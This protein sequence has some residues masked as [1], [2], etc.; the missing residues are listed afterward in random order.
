ME[1]TALSDTRQF[2]QSIQDNSVCTTAVD[3]YNVG[4]WDVFILKRPIFYTVANVAVL[5]H[6]ASVLNVDGFVGEFG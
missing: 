6:V 4:V 2:T 3:E 5:T 1:F